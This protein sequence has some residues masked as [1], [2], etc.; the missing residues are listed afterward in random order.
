LKQKF[1]ILPTSGTIR[2]RQEDKIGLDAMIRVQYT[3][4]K[5]EDGNK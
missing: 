5:K 1:I 2:F 3:M 4:N